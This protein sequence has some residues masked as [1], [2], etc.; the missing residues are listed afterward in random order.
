[1]ECPKAA[2]A[3]I[4]KATTDSIYTKDGTFYYDW[5]GKF[6][7]IEENPYYGDAVIG[8]WGTYRYK[9]VYDNKKLLSTRMVLSLFQLLISMKMFLFNHY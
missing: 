7:S 8:E 6:L 3:S 5:C 9:V 2:F 1:M 4:S